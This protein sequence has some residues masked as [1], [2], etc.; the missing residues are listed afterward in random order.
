MSRS[1]CLN[2]SFLITKIWV[3]VIL[4]R[5]EDGFVF[6]FWKLWWRWL[7]KHYLVLTKKFITKKKQK[8]KIIWWI[9]TWIRHNAIG[10]SYNS[11]KQV[12]S[13][14]IVIIRKLK[15]LFVMKP[16]LLS[17]GT[18]ATITFICSHFL[19]ALEFTITMQYNWNP[20]P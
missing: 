13:E 10:F 7:R 20:R 15:Y 5:L 12:E 18:I 6:L 11:M 17:L 2:L 19:L 14:R 8:K 4:R 16:T 3:N 9:Y 1:N